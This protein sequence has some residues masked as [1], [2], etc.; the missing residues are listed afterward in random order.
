[1][2]GVDT[3]TF[4]A[5]VPGTFNIIDQ[6]YGIGAG[7]FDLGGPY[8]PN[9]DYEAMPL[10]VGS[11]F[12][13]GWTVGGPGDGIKWL[14]P[15]SLGSVDLTLTSSSSIFTMIPTVPGYLYQFEFYLY[16]AHAGENNEVLFTFGSFTAGAVTGDQQPA[17]HI[18]VS[19]YAN[20]DQTLVWFGPQNPVPEAGTG[21]FI[22]DVSVTLVAVPEPSTFALLA[23][24]ALAAAPVIRRRERV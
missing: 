19:K 8:V 12:L 18:N 10:R 7:A 20:S 23:L 21:P 11:T 6:T 15:G 3:L 24:A 4:A 14:G 2:V 5:V 16:P 9:G 1:M 22:D 17:V 13:T